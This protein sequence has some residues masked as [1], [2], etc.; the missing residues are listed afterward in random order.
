MS[1]IHLYLAAVRW[2]NSLLGYPD[3][4]TSPQLRL[5]LRGIQRRVSSRRRTRFGISPQLLEECIC[6]LRRD[7][8]LPRWDR[9]M[10]QAA[11]T[12][13]FFGLLRASEFTYPSPNPKC[14]DGSSHLTTQD[15]SFSQEDALNVHLKGSKTDQLRHG[16]GITIGATQSR[17]CPVKAMKRY[18]QIRPCQQRRKIPL[19]LFENG[20]L[21]TRSSLVWHLRRQL[22]TFQV[23]P[24]LYS[25]HSF[26]IGGA[27][28]AAAAGL[29]SWQIQELGRWRSQAFRRY[30]RVPNASL[31]GICKALVIS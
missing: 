20:D 30:M 6:A 28:A 29:P 11:F 12:M 1:T 7:H 18:L 5:T 23:N 16:M 26:R 15:I 24:N 25:S 19:F 2:Y 3:I 31:R 8:S 4:T 21:L 22:K 27:T 17:S 14:F 9:C 10:L 13:A